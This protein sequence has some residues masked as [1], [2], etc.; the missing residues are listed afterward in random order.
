LTYP[1]WPRTSLHNHT[2]FRL[3]NVKKYVA[4][5]ELS[6][7]PINHYLG[8]PPSDHTANSRFNDTRRSRN[9][10]RL[11]V[12]N[13]FRLSLR[14]AKSPVAPWPNSRKLSGSREDHCRL[15]WSLH[16]RLDGHH[17]LVKRI[18]ARFNYKF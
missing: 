2:D 5:R 3:W 17:L 6:T 15:V 12:E 16:T 18:I 13:T 4:T 7:L 8:P 9:N 14:L 11:I 10:Q 1:G